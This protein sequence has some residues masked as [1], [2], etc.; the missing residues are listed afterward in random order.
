MNGERFKAV[1]VLRGIWHIRDEMD[2]CMTLLEGETEALLVDTGYGTADVGAFVSTLTQKPL[3]VILTHGHHDHAAGARW[4]PETW[5]FPQDR[6]DFALYAGFPHRAKL[7]EQARA[8]GVALP[9]DFLRAENPMPRPLEERTLD[10]GG[11]TAQIRLCP[12]HTPGSA[13]VYVPQRELLLTGDDWNPCTWLFFPR[14]LPV[15]AYRDNVRALMDIPFRQ[16]LCSHR[17]ELYGREMMEQ[18]LE[19]LTDRALAEARRVDVGY[20]QDTRQ[21]SLPGDQV[22]V[23]DWNKFID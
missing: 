1:E 15:R 22:L 18:F 8:K 21:V 6:E 10:L 17:Q 14:A 13:V 16:V 20:P 3:T 4:F 2:V 11:M 19:G 12:G 23:F 9:E 7:A 5:M